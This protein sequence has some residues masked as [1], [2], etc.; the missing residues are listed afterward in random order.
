MSD[1]ISSIF[2]FVILEISYLYNFKG[3]N[4]FFLFIVVQQFREAEDLISNLEEGSGG[5]GLVS[6]RISLQDEKIRMKPTIND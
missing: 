4:L 6:V 2:V 5:I 3:Y 1:V